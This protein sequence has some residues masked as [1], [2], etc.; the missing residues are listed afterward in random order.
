[1][2][3]R[4]TASK[5]RRKGG[6]KHRAGKDQAAKIPEATERTIEMVDHAGTAHSLTMTAAQDG[7]PN[8][9]YTG[10]CGGDV[11]PAA[12]AAREARYC[13]L[14]VPIIPAQRSHA[15]STTNAM[16]IRWGLSVLDWRSHA[17]DEHRRC[18]PVG[19]YEAECGHLLMKV[20]VLRDELPGAP[21]PECAALQLDVAQA[22]LERAANGIRQA[23]PHHHNE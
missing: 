12:L 6:G 20:T 17:I 19:V 1:M 23:G 4:R 16:N 2:A 11:P 13:R 9:R 10:V 5:D 21:C 15:V 3:M 14:C 22:A 8:G 18:H 7:L